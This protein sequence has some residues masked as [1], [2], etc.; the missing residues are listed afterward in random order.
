MTKRAPQNDGRASAKPRRFPFDLAAEWDLLAHHWLNEPFNRSTV[1]PIPGWCSGLNI[2]SLAKRNSHLGPAKRS[3]RRRS[4][5]NSPSTA[6]WA[7]SIAHYR[8]LG[9]AAGKSA[10]WWR[11]RA[12]EWPS[13][14]GVVWD[15]VTCWAVTVGL[16]GYLYPHKPSIIRQKFTSPHKAIVPC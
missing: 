2:P 1:Q 11:C 7:P 10:G 16:L 13:E 14:P 9:P 3:W 4:S 12:W 5:C 8:C 6:L 15:L